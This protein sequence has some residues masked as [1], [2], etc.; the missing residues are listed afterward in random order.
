D[1]V[2]L[3]AFLA[4][5]LPVMVSVGW[6]S[7]G[8]HYAVVSGYDDFT[9]KLTIES[10]DG[11]GREDAQVDYQA[12]SDAWARHGNQMTAVLPQR[13]PRLEPLLRAGDPRRPTEIPEGFS[14]SNFWVSRQGK[15]YVEAA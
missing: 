5:G 1:L 15:V 3:R 14:L 11:R 8:G 2:K 13:D 7:G 6:K 10:W 12:F 4:A 9:G